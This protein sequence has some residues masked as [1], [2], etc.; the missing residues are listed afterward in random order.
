MASRSIKFKRI[1][2]FDP[3][4]HG[5]QEPFVREYI[6]KCKRCKQTMSYEETDKHAVG[7]NGTS[8]TIDIS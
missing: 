4:V 8:I 6:Y 1:R 2:V 7:H 5:V 3:S